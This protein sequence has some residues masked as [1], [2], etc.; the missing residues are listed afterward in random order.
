MFEYIAHAHVNE[1]HGSNGN[2]NTCRENTRIGT[3]VTR[4]HSIIDQP[5]QVRSPPTHPCPRKRIGDW[6]VCF[7][8][9]SPHRNSLLIV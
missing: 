3:V 7:K 5:V 6:E 8:S 1:L 2:M 9:K 4:M